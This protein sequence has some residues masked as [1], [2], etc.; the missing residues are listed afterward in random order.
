M[1]RMDGPAFLAERANDPR[2][3]AV[4]VVVLTTSGDARDVKACYALGANS[5]VTKPIDFKDYCSA[6]GAIR[7]FWT[8]VAAVPAAGSG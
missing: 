8:S 5:F 1:P 7:R 6:V 3:R 4:P 2:L